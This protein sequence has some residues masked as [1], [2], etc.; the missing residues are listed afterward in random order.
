[1]G[2]VSDAFH[3]PRYGFV[4][5]TIFAGLFFAGLLVNRIYDP[6]QRHLATLDRASTVPPNLSR[7]FHCG[8][9]QPL[10]KKA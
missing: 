7:M 10:K 9:L 4:R 2:A 1:M 6:A 3:H 5:A 8:A